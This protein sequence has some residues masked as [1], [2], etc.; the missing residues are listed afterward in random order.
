MVLISVRNPITNTR[1]TLTAGNL[2]ASGSGADAFAGARR[3]TRY[4]FQDSLTYIL[5][6]HTIKGGFDAQRVNSKAV[7]LGDATGTFNFNS[8]LQ[9]QNNEISR[10]RQNFGDANDV[11][12]TYYGVFINDEFK[13]LSNV[14]L[15]YGLRY[16]RETAISDNNNFGPRIGVAW[17]PFKKGKGVVR[18][19][20]GIFYN[21]V[22][23]RTVADFIQNST[24]DLFRFD[25]NTIT[26]ANG[27]QANVLARIA[28]QFPAGFASAQAIRNLVATVN[29]GTTAVPVACSPNTGFLPNLGSAGNPLRSVDPNLK[30][31]ESYQFNVGFERELTSDLSARLEKVWFL[32]PIIPGTKPFAC[33]AISTRMRLLFQPDFRILRHIC[34]Q[35]LLS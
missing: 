12:N 3:E 13:V 24:P 34:W 14:T 33:G 27:A 6:A 4:Q 28:Q 16:E 2:S 25:T 7:V 22:L 8:V 11:R 30:I 32:K 21:R 15:N 23:L 1:Q 26:T 18:F 10:F 31:P 5:G 19:G 35:I 17:D 20:A 29:C 9:Y